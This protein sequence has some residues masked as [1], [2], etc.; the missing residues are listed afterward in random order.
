MSEIASP[1]TESAQST[2]EPLL[3][4]R[5]LVT[6]FHSSE[7]V[8]KAVDGVSYSVDRGEVLAV[9]ARLRNE[10]ESVVARV[11]SANA[12]ELFALPPE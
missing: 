7:G 12:R 6:E 1:Q 9:V 8:F 10:D 4:V 5:G 3:D 11:T 2:L